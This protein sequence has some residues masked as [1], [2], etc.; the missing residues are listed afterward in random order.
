MMK[1][2][3]VESDSVQSDAFLET[4][5]VLVS[6]LS[7]KQ[8]G[9][10]APQRSKSR[11]V[12]SAQL[13]PGEPQKSPRANPAKS[14]TSQFGPAQRAAVFKCVED[15]LDIM[16][17]NG[18]E[19]FLELLRLRYNLTEDEI[20][21]SPGRFMSILKVFFDTSARVF[22]RN[23]LWVMERDLGVSASTFEEAVA[24]FKAG[25][26]SKTAFLAPAGLPEAE[27]MTV[28]DTM[29]GRLNPHLERQGNLD[30]KFI[31]HCRIEQ[32]EGTVELV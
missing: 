21:E 17:H 3:Y 16:G 12:L 20:V 13:A 29:V 11:Q 15:A 23:I 7:N 30:E 22:E 9:V 19:V 5:S 14:Q 2:S 24:S 27:V 10:G 4:M 1:A 6:N 31:Y 26:E 32:R 8:F 25:S 28:D 18:K